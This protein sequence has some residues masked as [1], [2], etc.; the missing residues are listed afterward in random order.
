M[1]MGTQGSL[2]QTWTTVLTAT[3][4]KL[5][6]QNRVNALYPNA[7]NANISQKNR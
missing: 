2:R 7:V 5:G 4:L 3:A 6:A 1:A